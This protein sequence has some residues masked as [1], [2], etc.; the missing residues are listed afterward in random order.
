LQGVMEGDKG[1]E[2]ESG[3]E[4]VGEDVAGAQKDV[5]ES[6]GFGVLGR[7]EE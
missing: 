1:A 7:V 6:S 4:G 2:R 5:A 3:M